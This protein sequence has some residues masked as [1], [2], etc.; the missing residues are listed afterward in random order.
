MVGGRSLEDLEAD[1]DLGGDLWLT[2]GGHTGLAFV[3]GFYD[4]GWNIHG[5]GRKQ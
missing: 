2:C 4:Y 1:H 3:A 5:A